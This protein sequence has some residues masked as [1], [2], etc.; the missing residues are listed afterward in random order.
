MQQ[1]F[2]AIRIHPDDNVAVLVQGAQPGQTLFIIGADAVTVHEAIPFGHKVALRD[3]REGEAVKKYGFPIGQASR[4]IHRGDWIHSH[5]LKTALTAHASYRYERTADC[6]TASAEGAFLGYLRENGE[7][8][9]RNE[10]WILPMVSCVNHTARLIAEQIASLP[11]HIDHL[12]AL[13]QPFGCSQLGE[14]HASTVAILRDIALHPNCAGVLLLSLGCEN[15]TMAEFLAGLGD[16]D[17]RRVRYLICQ[18]HEDEIGEGIRLIEELFESTRDDRR[19]LQPLSKLRVGFKCGASDGFSGIT[20]NPLAG[21]VC[22]LLVK[23]GATAVLTEVPEMFG[24]ETQLMN[25]ARD[26]EIFNAIVSMIENFK[27]Y[28]VDHNQPVYE[29]PSPGNKEGGITTLS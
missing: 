26:G 8:G 29:N 28:Y 18:E 19:T 20:A 7:V 10:I 4:E 23:N 1:N 13:E 27:Q 22:D 2:D 12:H 5:N 15:N 16:Y 6:V 9:I 24:A 3:I 11:P 17:K 21:R 25:R 14:D